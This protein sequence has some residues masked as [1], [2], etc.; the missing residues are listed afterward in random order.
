[1]VASW[2]GDRAVLPMRVRF[3]RYSA[4]DGAYVTPW[5][6]VREIHE[7]RGADPRAVGGAAYAAPTLVLA[8]IVAGLGATLAIVGAT[9]DEWTAARRRGYLL[10]GVA[11][12]AFGLGL[13]AFILW[14]LLGPSHTV[15]RR[16]PLA[17]P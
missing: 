13:D 16:P 6:N 10:V 17:S 15:V 4:L 11:T 5:S 12:A 8:T 7:R 2:L 14:H 9:S 3:G 1:T